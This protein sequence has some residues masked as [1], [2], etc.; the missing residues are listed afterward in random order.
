MIIHLKK[1]ASITTGLAS[2]KIY[3]DILCKRS[4][5][6]KNIFLFVFF[7]SLPTIYS[8]TEDEALLL[9]AKEWIVFG[10]ESSQDQARNIDHGE[11]SPDKDAKVK[12]RSKLMNTL[13]D[14]KRLL[15]QSDPLAKIRESG[16]RPI[17]LRLVKVNHYK[18]RLSNTV[19][20]VWKGSPNTTSSLGVTY[21]PY[22]LKDPFAH[23]KMD[24][25][26]IGFGMRKYLQDHFY[27]QGNVG[28][29][30][31]KP[32]SFYSEYFQDRGAEFQGQNIPYLTVGMG[33]RVLKS[34]P[35]LKMPLVL[36]AEYTIA[37]DLNFPVVGP[38]G[39]DRIEISGLKI[40][41]SVRLKI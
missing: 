26:K 28:Y 31:Y 16:L 5:M 9:K 7:V 33:V 39:H 8:A 1:G 11:S 13:R 40:G 36:R 41:V 25:W 21:T 38:H 2:D 29:H 20:Y 4:N 17:H 34:I 6:Y 30:I 10:D 37:E 22:I 12:G 14:L 3:A 15:F 35:I 18:T 19:S 32:N 27:I 24:S 23:M